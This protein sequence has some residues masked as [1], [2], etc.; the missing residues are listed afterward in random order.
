MDISSFYAY[1]TRA[2]R[3]LVSCLE[4]VPDD[5]LSRALIGG[6]KFHSI[7]DLLFHIAEAEDGWLNMELLGREPVLESYPSLLAELGRPS[8]GKFP[9]EHILEYWR[10]VEEKSTKTLAQ[11]TRTDLDLRIEV[12]D[13]Q[14]EG[15]DNPVRTTLE[16]LLWHVLQHEVRHTAQI[17]LLLRQQGI[18][19][20]SLD[21]LFYLPIDVNP[22]D[23]RL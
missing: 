20:P 3:D 6:S 2:R 13:L 8:Y 9:L 18:T 1:L 15:G 12:E 23:S 17:V 19:P 7:K 14:K 5:L 21:L 11:T 16:S 10:E 22:T 4:K